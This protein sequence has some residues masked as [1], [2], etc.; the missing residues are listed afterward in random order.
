VTISAGI[1]G[2]GTA[3]NNR[4]GNGGNLI[5]HAGV[6]GAKSGSGSVG[7]NGLIK[8]QNSTIIVPPSGAVGALLALSHTGG[9][10]ESISITGSS[11]SKGQITTDSGNISF[12]PG[13]SVKILDLATNLATLGGPIA[14][15]GY[16]VA[17]LPSTAG[18][19]M[20]AGA[21]AHVTDSAASPTFLGTL[22][23]GGAVV[24]PVFFNGVAWVPA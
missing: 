5:L 20:V 4:G 15:K 19:G 16:T 23:G 6:G 9:N 14:T 24:C 21:R 18:A 2:A 11:A 8:L 13:N 17:T 10:G 1:G 12:W 3:G 7:N 22:T